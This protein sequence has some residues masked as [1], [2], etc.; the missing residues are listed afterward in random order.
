MFVQVDFG[1]VRNA[2]G[3]LEPKLVELQ[4][5]PSLYG[6]QPTAAHQYVESYGLAPDLGVYLSGCDRNAYW[7]LMRQLIVADH[8]P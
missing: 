8:D 7:R 3:D 6:Y 5:F 2:A 1:L 4:A